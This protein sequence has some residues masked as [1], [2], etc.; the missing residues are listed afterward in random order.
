MLQEILDFISRDLLLLA[1]RVEP[2]ELLWRGKRKVSFSDARVKVKSAHKAEWQECKR[3]KS[4]SGQE[5]SLA[6][7]QYS[8]LQPKGQRSQP[9]RAGHAH[10]L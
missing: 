5:D 4:P 3:H 7:V 9:Q 8:C 2:G 1:R 10:D 6:P